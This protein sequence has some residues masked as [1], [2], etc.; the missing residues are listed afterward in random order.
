VPTAPM[1]PPRPTPART[2]TA[3]TAPATA[4]TIERSRFASDG[5]Q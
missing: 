3:A 1:A 4:T 2:T 5:V